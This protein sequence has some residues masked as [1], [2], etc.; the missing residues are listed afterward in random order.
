MIY[1]ALGPDNV[2]GE[3]NQ[4][5]PA[6][7]VIGVREQILNFRRELRTMAMKDATSMTPDERYNFAAMEKIIEH[8]YYERD[9]L[10]R[11]IETSTWVKEML[12]S[13]GLA[14]NLPSS[15][16]TSQLVMQ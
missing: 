6:N 9:F 14:A 8:Q 11:S 7:Q 4:L 16:A 5:S 12:N 15:T 13:I 3:I 1:T 2:V 10:D